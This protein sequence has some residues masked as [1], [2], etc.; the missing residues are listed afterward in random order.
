MAGVR[1]MRITLGILVA[2]VLL[3][4]CGDRSSPFAL[5]DG[6][7]YAERYGTA[8]LRVQGDQG[9]ILTPPP[10]PDPDAPGFAPIPV[11]RV[12]LRPRTDRDGA[13]VEATPGFYLDHPLFRAVASGQPSVRM[14]I[15]TGAAG[16]AILAPIEA[17]GDVPLRLGRPCAAGGAPGPG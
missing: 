2:T 12:H 7:Y 8:V 6:C 1:T 15:E 10:V 14:A 16:P 3:P 4:G 9:F 17:Y 11:R 5:P 13:Y